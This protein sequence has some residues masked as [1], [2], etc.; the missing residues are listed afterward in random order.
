MFYGFPRSN[1][2]AGIRNTVGIIS[3]MDNVNGI[4]RRIAENVCGTE[5]VTDLF[6][7]KLIGLNHEMRLK[8]IHGMALN[9]NIGGV[10]LV[11]LHDVS[12]ETFAGSIAA[13]GKDVETVV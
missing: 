2:S 5:L 11:T 10:I 1:G 13:A 6:G 9:P 3:L 7:R 4:A 12:A 8:A